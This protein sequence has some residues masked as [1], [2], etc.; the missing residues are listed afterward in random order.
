MASIGIAIDPSPAKRPQRVTIRGRYVSIVPLDPLAHG[1]ALYKGTHGPQHD[2]LWVY[3]FDGPFPNRP[4]L[5][6]SLAQPL[7]E[8]PDRAGAFGERRV[9]GLAASGDLDFP[10]LPL[11]IGLR[12]GQRNGHP[13]GVGLEVFGPDSGKF[14]PAQESREPNQDH[15]RSRDAVKGPPSP[16]STLMQ[17]IFVQTQA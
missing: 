9:F 3:L 12:P 14:R 4:A 13:P 11:L 5:D 16:I 17:F 10:S 6:A 15:A 2:S 8:R 7:V 1:E